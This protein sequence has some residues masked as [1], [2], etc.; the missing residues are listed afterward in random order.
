MSVKR[1]NIF[2][3]LAYI[4]VL[5]FCMQGFHV[6]ANPTPIKLYMLVVPIIL[7]IIL[8]D[9]KIKM[10]IAL[11]EKA[12]LIFFSYMVLSA[13]WAPD[14]SLSLLKIFGILLLLI[15]YFTIRA[16]LE[17]IDNED[18]FNLVSNAGLTVFVLSILYYL[19]GLLDLDYS[20]LAERLE[21]E[22]RGF[23]GLYLEGTMPRMRGIFDSPNNLGIICVFFYHF[24]TSFDVKYAR[25]GRILSII[26][27]ILTIS[28]TS[29]I[30][31]LISL[32][33]QVYKVRYLK[34]LL[35]I[36]VISYCL[37]YLANQL[38]PM[39]IVDSIVSA[40]VE[41]LYTG[42]GRDELFLYS[43]DGIL[44]RPL[45]GYGLNQSRM[46]FVD[47]RG[48]QSSH[49]S[50]LEAAIDGGLIGFILLLVSWITF[51]ILAM[52]VSRLTGNSFYILT[53]FS[54]FLFSQANL[55]TYVEL[56]ILYFALWM[57]LFRT[58]LM[59]RLSS[60]FDCE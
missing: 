57:S 30:V 1:R 49:N 4:L 29:W 23:W 40:R 20:I 54:L 35:F 48:F 52:R 32:A 45:L 31:I 27:I 17:S 42:S 3:S 56:V 26:S 43:I 15:S 14:S 33:L 24:Y 34:R 10:R 50:F 13:V 37:I 51:L 55:L 28:L 19:I 47:F 7:A 21:G 12:S 11:P 41:R 59:D 18:L 53:A 46:L 9:N 16:T 8:I 36:G 22:E 60:G 58:R 44:E 5:G 25:L 38:M 39:D 6:Y 2:Y